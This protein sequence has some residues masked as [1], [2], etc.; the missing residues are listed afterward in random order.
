[1]RDGCRDCPEK[2]AAHASTALRDS[3]AGSSLA[4]LPAPS[5]AFLLLLCASCHERAP[6][7]P[8]PSGLSGGCR[9]SQLS[10]LVWSQEKT[11]LLCLCM[12]LRQPVPTASVAKAEVTNRDVATLC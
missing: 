12:Y 2:R 10:W 11:S 6:L 7:M 5:V 8:S 9:S 3:V 4:Q 1:M